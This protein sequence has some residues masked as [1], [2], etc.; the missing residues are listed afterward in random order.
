MLT[1]LIPAA[2]DRTLQP[3]PGVRAQD[4][5][6]GH[7]DRCEPFAE[8]LLRRAFGHGRVRAEKPAY[9]DPDLPRKAPEGVGREQQAV[10]VAKERDVPEAVAR[11]GDDAKTRD[12][13]TLAKDLAHGARRHALPVRHAT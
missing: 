13:V 4:G 2:I 7:H 10:R 3:R 11:R 9:A 8:Q 6:V 5:A 12:D 1:A